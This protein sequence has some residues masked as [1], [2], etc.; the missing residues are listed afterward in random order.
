M[1]GWLSR[2]DGSLGAR[3][4][5][6]SGRRSH[7]GALGLHVR[8]PFGESVTRRSIGSTR[9]Y[10]LVLAHTHSYPLVPVRARSY[11]FVPVAPVRTRSCPFPLAPGR[12]RSYPLVPARARSYP[13]GPVRTSFRR[14][15][16]LKKCLCTQTVR[17]YEA[18]RSG[19]KRYVRS[20]TYVR[21]YVRRG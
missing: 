3:R 20:G 8:T 15:P 17:T 2:E 9:S 5:L 18:V 13:P 12:T 10:P 7:D 11:A 6:P 16:V 1:G 19:T 21:T 14:L 4:R